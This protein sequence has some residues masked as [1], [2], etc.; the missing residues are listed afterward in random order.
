MIAVSSPSF[1]AIPFPQ[2]LEA[3]SQEF[4]AW[5]IVAEGGHELSGI[6]E[7]F[8][9]LTPLYGMR[10]SVHAPMSDINIGSLNPRMREAS[11][12]ELVVGL[13]A[14]GRLG[15]D[16][17]TVHPAFLTPLGFVHRDGV[18]EAARTSLLRLDQVANDVGVRVALENMPRMYTATGTRPQELTEL[19]EGTGLGI[20]LDIGHAHTNGLI[21]EF[22]PLRDR[23]INVH[24]HD[25]RGEFDEHLP[26]GDGTIDFPA[27][28]RG[29]E[30][31]RGNYVI[32]SRS[33]PEGVRSRD[34]LTALLNDL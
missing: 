24:I 34:R 18:K 31:Y 5:E 30:G 16:T 13:E 20:C 14:C 33:L 12:R 9:E 4:K 28:L 2:A 17:Y 6:E 8:R 29:L 19:I 23:I 10:F 21:A 11:L 3:I 22:L 7:R 27:V 32:E 25:N 15:I 26:I 1:T